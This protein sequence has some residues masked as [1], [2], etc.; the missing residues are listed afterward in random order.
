MKVIL[1]SYLLALLIAS[2]IQASVTST[3][4]SYNT[5][6]SSV[7]YTLTLTFSSITIPASSQ[8]NIIF[9]SNF[10]IN[11]STLSSCTYLTN[12]GSSY[13]PASCTPSTNT[14]NTIIIFTGIY[15]SIANSQTSLSVKVPFLLNLVCNKQP[16]DSS[17]F[18]ILYIFNHIERIKHRGIYKHYQFCSFTSQQLQLGEFINS[19]WCISNTYYFLHPFSSNYIWVIFI[20]NT[21]NLVLW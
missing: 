6:A 11:S 17:C 3:L 15:N 4:S 18:I 14:T 13:S 19:K 20:N 9:S 5:L 21:T 7:T 16:L 1:S 12:S 8:V 2:S 10:N